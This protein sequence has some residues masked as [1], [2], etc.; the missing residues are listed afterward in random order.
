MK[1]QEGKFSTS[2]WMNRLLTNVSNLPIIAKRLSSK[3]N[4]NQAADLQN[5]YTPP[6]NASNCSVHQFIDEVTNTVMDTVGRCSS[7]Q[8]DASFANH[9]ARLVAQQNLDA[10]KWAVAHL[11]SGKV[12]HAKPRDQHNKMQN[13]VRHATLAPDGLLITTSDH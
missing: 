10:C 2:S 6:C 4:L 8:V 9:Q 5:R 11:T 1:I 7:F 3:F 12:Q 13:Y